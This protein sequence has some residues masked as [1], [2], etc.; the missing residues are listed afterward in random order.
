MPVN[1]K[2]M[3]TLVEKIVR[4]PL[5]PQYLEKIQAFW[6]KEEADRKRFY[7]DVV[8]NKKME[9]INGEVYFQSPVK[10]RH[11]ETGKLLLK[12]IDVYVDANG[13]GFVGYEKMLVS[14]TRNDYEPDLC[15]WNKEKSADFKP[16]QMQ[17][18]A[19]DL[20]IEI[21][22]ES[23]EKIDRGVKFEDYAE[24]NVAEYWIID[25]RKKIVEQYIAEDKKY[26]LKHK[27]QNQ[28]IIFCQVLQGFNIPVQAIFD[29]AENVKILKQLLS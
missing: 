12:L 25:P 1:F 23:T 14:L 29:N 19:P 5:L 17:F 15:F 13:L 2:N 3:E 28:E 16:D 10:L 20:V 27:A 21:L 11:N 7:K 22:S 26:G 8:E 18:P 9:F 24:H 6:K 4:S